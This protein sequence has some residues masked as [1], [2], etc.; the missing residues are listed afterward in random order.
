VHVLCWI[1]TDADP[2]LTLRLS[3]HHKQPRHYTSK[4][5]DVFVSGMEKLA[6]AHANVYI[7]IS[8][9]CYTCKEW[10]TNPLVVETIYKVI[11]I[12]GTSRCFFASNYPVDIK[13]G[14][15]VSHGLTPLHGLVSSL[16]IILVCCSSVCSI[17]ELCYVLL[18]A[19]SSCTCKTRLLPPS[20]ISMSSR[21]CG[22]SL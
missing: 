7:K 14:W 3:S 10:D 1:W 21:W 20:G 22:P 2:Q 16:S 8:M 11:D 12:F 4:S 15:P 18:Y 17:V 5:N 6:A 19:Q 9:L 13:D